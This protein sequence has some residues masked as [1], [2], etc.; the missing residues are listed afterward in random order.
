MSGKYGAT[1]GNM[2]IKQADL[3]WGLSQQFIQALTSEA[4]KQ[5]FQPGDI[6][7]RSDDPANNFYVLIRGK[8][9]LEIGKAGQGVYFSERTGEVIGWSTLIGR[10]KY[11]ATCVCE[12]ATVLLMFDKGHITR[13]L[14]RDTESASIFFKHLAAA[15][16]DRLLKLYEMIQQ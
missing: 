11:S 7:F 12:Q 16:G 4:T 14:N 10:E 5:T 9:R 3:F 15:L 8:I 2:Y 6:V 13:L 1:G